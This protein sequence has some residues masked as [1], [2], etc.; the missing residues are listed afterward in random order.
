MQNSTDSKKCAINN[1]LL[2]M[3]CRCFRS[4]APRSSVF[5]GPK[6]VWQTFRCSFLCVIRA[7]RSGS[8]EN[9]VSIW[10]ILLYTVADIKSQI[11]RTFRAKIYFPLR[12]TFTTLILADRFPEHLFKINWVSAKWSHK[13]R[14]DTD[15]DCVSS[16]LLSGFSVEMWNW[17]FDK[18][19]KWAN[20]E[21]PMVRWAYRYKDM[22]Q[23]QLSNTSKWFRILY[24][25]KFNGTHGHLE[26]IFFTSDA[27]HFLHCPI[28]RI[29]SWSELHIRYFRISNAHHWK[30]P[31]IKIHMPK[32]NSNK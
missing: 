11:V 32:T 3:F 17:T 30:R 7:F 9:G 4:L 5:S 1:R 27:L 31:R 12:R 18:C 16:K 21:D 22:A 8:H 19:E 23:I 2:S 29:L 26:S 25:L 15:F 13:F 10:Q 28:T 20:P 6:W 14:A 24:E